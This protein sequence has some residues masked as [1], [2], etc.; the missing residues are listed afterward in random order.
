MSQNILFLAHVDETGKTLPK[1]A[2]QVLGKAVDLAANTGGALTIG[3]VGENIHDAA[4]ELASTATR[5]LGVSG[6]DFT[7]PRYATDAAAAEA[8]CRA[9]SPEL[10]IAPST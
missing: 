5:I 7:H 8:L 9:A 6:A 1:V 10:V 4:N 2:F 3:L